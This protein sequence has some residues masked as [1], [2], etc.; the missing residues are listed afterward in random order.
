[1]LY[2]DFITCAVQV[3]RNKIFDGLQ[4]GILVHNGATG[5][6][7]GNKISNNRLAGISVQSKG[8]PEVVDNTVSKGQVGL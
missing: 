2:L 5:V 7:T 4:C 8:A 3:L 6:V 1:M